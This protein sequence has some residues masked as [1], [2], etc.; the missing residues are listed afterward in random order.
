MPNLRLLSILA[1]PGLS[2]CSLPILSGDMPHLESITLPF[3]PYG[4]QVVQLTHLTSISI[5]VDYSAL[6]DVIGLFANNP[7]LRSAT[8]CGTFS[9]ESCRWRH[10][11]VCMNSLR[12]LDLLSWGATSLL[13]FLTLK[14]GAHIRVFGPPYGLGMAG[15]GDLF[16]SDT[17]SLPNLIGLKKLC[18]YPVAHDTLMELTG[19]NG[20]FSI[21]LPWS[22]PHA[23]TADSFPLRDVEELYCESDGTP[24]PMITAD[25]LN[26]MIDGMI[27]TMTRLRKVTFAMCTNS[28]IQTVLTDLN[29][30]TRLKSITLSHCDYP[31]PTYDVFHALLLFAKRRVSANAKLEEVRVICRENAQRLNSSI[32]DYRRWSSRSHWFTNHHWKRVGQISKSSAGSL[33]RSR[34]HTLCTLKP[35]SGQAVGYFF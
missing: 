5:T 3:F 24:S 18:W 19:P 13:P 28:F 30:A 12:Q 15:A 20:G 25:E 4:Q 27:P 16:P 21:L 10:G 6:A 26:R 11:A 32:A 34:K 23:F 14:E 9:D 7:E 29:R 22:E 1:E 33:R 17:T 8:L 35:S 2:P 31:D